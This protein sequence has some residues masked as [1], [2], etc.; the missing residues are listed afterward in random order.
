MAFDNEIRASSTMVFLCCTELSNQN[1]FGVSWN[2][3]RSHMPSD[4]KDFPS[5]SIAVTCTSYVA[6]G[7]TCLRTYFW[8]RRTARKRR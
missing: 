6:D 4:K 1:R 3:C 7:S 2:L 5:R 8:E